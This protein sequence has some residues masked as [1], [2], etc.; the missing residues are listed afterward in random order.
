[1]RRLLD[2]DM[3]E[4]LFEWIRQQEWYTRDAVIIEE[5]QTGNMGE[6][7]QFDVLVVADT[8]R[9]FEIKSDADTFGKRWHSQVYK[10]SSICPYMTLVT[11]RKMNDKVP[12]KDRVTGYRKSWG[13]NLIVDDG[14]GITC[15]QA[16]TPRYSR[17]LAPYALAEFLYVKE[18]RDLLK[19]RGVKGVD[20][21]S[22]LPLLVKAGGMFTVDELI[23]IVCNKLGYRK[24][25]IGR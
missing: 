8:L 22:K 13:L 5:R 10:F 7:C 20:K 15:E 2:K 16:Y 1:M 9:G 3:R 4:P 23:Q 19:S 24:T 21:L 11:T 12:F 25:R 14:A 18:L 17:H 6:Y